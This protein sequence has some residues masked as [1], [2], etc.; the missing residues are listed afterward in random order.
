MSLRRFAL[1]LGLS[2][3]I[4]CGTVGPA[5][6]F[7]PRAAIE[8]APAETGASSRA[9]HA[10]NDAE[11]AVNGETLPIDKLGNSEPVFELTDAE[12]CACG[13]KRTPT[14]C[15]GT[16]AIPAPR[17]LQKCHAQAD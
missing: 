3:A 1:L 17:S 9:G 16:E 14:S 8:S 4:G 13:I 15:P 5:G 11:F 6:H 12:Y 7:E 2:A 10:R